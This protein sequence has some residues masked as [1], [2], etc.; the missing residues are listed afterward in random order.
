ME[1]GVGLDGPYG[2]LPTQEILSGTSGSRMVDT[3]N[4]HGDARSGAEQ[5]ESPT[6]QA[7]DGAF[8]LPVAGTV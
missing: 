1:P 6:Q 4:E 5:G 2:S 7:G 8:I 3:G